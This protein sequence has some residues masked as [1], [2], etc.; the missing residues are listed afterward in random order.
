MKPWFEKEL[1]EADI[2]KFPD[3]KAKVIRMPNVQ[4]YPDFITGVKDLQAKQKDGTISQETYDKLY[5]DLIHRFMKKESFD[6]PWYLREA[7]GERLPNKSTRGDMN[8]PLLAGAIVTRFMKYPELVTPSS[9]KQTIN[10]MRKTKTYDKEFIAD[11]GQDKIDYIIKLN[12][13]KNID[14]WNDKNLIKN[15]STELEA[16]IDFV[17]TD[18]WTQKVAHVLTQNN[19]PDRIQVIASGPV[20]QKLSK[21]DVELIYYK[22]N[23]KP[24]RIKGISLKTAGGDLFGQTS[25]NPKTLKNMKAHQEWW[26]RLG[27]TIAEYSYE[28]YMEKSMA[29]VQN[30]FKTAVKQIEQQLK[31]DNDRNEKV[32][33]D[34]AIAFLD[35]A[36][37]LNDKELEVLDIKGGKYSVQTVKQLAKN[38]QNINLSVVGADLETSVPKI[39]FFGTNQDNEKIELFRIRHTYSPK[40]I[41]SKGKLK[42]ARH[43]I[44]V[45][46]GPLFTDLATVSKSGKTQKKPQ[47]QPEPKKS[48]PAPQQKTAVGNDGQRYRHY[49]AQWINDKTGRIA[50]RGVADYLDK[51]PVGTQ[52]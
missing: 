19:K 52:A 6:T 31:G 36:V 7:E 20:D 37:A 26:S 12:A 46:P 42:A 48:S 43:R 47:A 3:P 23:G 40:R 16:D 51:S 8:E 49:G 44:F 30:T 22:P 25:P 13:E 38:I 1:A 27:V 2:L 35:F 34:K 28:D 21:I 41:S 15:M 50:T 5:T 24:K 4:S 11:N 39:I 32:F 14:D 45:V 18:R 33:L 10:T 9:V 29:I 17:N